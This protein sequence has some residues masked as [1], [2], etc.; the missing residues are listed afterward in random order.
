[1]RG[2]RQRAHLTR[3]CALPGG[4]RSERAALLLL[5]RRCL[6]RAVILRIVRHGRHRGHGLRHAGGGL[7][8]R[9]PA[10]H[11]ARRRDGLSGAA[12]RS[13][14]RWRMPWP[15]CW[16]T[17]RYCE[18][19]WGRQPS[20]RPG[21]IA[22]SKSRVAI[23]NTYLASNGHTQ[24]DERMTTDPALRQDEPVVRNFLSATC[25]RWL[26]RPTSL[27]WL[28]RRLHCARPCASRS[29]RPRCA[30]MVQAGQQGARSLLTTSPGRRRPISSCRRCSTSLTRRGNDLKLAILVACGT[31]RP[32]TAGRAAAPRWAPRSW[33][34]PR[35]Q[36]RC[37]RRAPACGRGQRPR[38]ARPFKVNRLVMESDL[39][40]RRS[41]T[42]CPH[43]L[44]GWSGG[45]KIIQPGVC[46]AETTNLDACHRHDV[47]RA[48]HGHAWTTRCASRSKRWS[49]AAKLHFIVNVVLN[50]HGEVV[51]VVAGHPQQA[52][53]RAGGAGRAQ[54][55]WCR[56]RP[57]PT[58]SWPARTRPT[59]TSGRGPRGS[60]ACELIIKRGGD[61]ILA[62]PCPERIAI[63]EHTEHCV[64]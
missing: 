42:S 63:H 17:R 24:G 49:S 52:H 13:V 34:L 25:W 37:L 6:R 7:S 26:S 5:C 33:R 31:H 27:A 51:H 46:S 9:R 14:W 41:A 56:C 59:W 54:S 22:G 53:R 19:G 2:L 21:P 23:L 35:P 28:T 50:R 45:A 36:P 18:R 16:A 30:S 47:A 39:V 64:P 8:R 60:I 32:M 29:A 61:I 4:S 62:T 43:S 3:A 11:G 12:G 57:C 58:S 20:Q 44:A 10:V 1:M 48:A 38:T 55:G 15:R 40:H